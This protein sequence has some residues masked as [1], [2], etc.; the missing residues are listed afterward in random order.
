MNA[1]LIQVI[2]FLRQRPMTAQEIADELDLSPT[3]ARRHVQ[4]LR[5]RGFWIEIDGA[6]RYHVLGRGTPE[7]REKVD[8]LSF[9]EKTEALDREMERAAYTYVLEAN[10]SGLMGKQTEDGKIVWRCGSTEV[11]KALDVDVETAGRILARLED[12]GLVDR[13][14]GPKGTRYHPREA[15][16]YNAFLRG[17]VQYDEK[18]SPD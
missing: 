18:S 7:K 4:R 1:R 16:I 3:T 2:R 14:G 17:L 11:A 9:R 15:W 6:G 10:V 12:R 13:C 8:G 5:E